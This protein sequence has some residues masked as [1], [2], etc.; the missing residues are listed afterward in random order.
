MQFILELVPVVD[1]TRIAVSMKIEADGI[2][3]DG[4]RLWVIRIVRVGVGL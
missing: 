3:A 2:V 4:I 1:T